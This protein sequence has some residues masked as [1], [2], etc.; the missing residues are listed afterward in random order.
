MKYFV[1]ANTCTGEVNFLSNNLNGI[2]KIYLIQSEFAF[3]V[4]T[5]IMRL[6]AYVQSQGS[7]IELIYNPLVVNTLDGFIMR[8][9][10]I[11]VLNSELMTVNNKSILVDIDSCIKK[12][13]YSYDVEL[14]NQYQT[15]TNQKKQC[16]YSVYEG[17]KKI[18]DEWEQLYIDNM[19]FEM[20]NSFCD[21]IINGF[22]IVSK[23]FNGSRCDRFFGAAYHNTNVNYID[24]ITSEIQT[25]YFI[26][27]RPGTGK[28]T[29]LKK[30]ANHFET[31]GYS[32]EVYHCG[33]DSNSLDMVVCRELSVCVFDSTS[34]HEKFPQK[35]SD[36][37]LDFYLN[38]G[39]GGVDEKLEPK[40]NDVKLR[41]GKM[42][43]LSKIYMEEIQQAYKNFESKIIPDTD[44][45]LLNNIVYEILYEII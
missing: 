30:L 35:V 33:F 45:Q 10:K 41:Y 1:R 28:S 15:E 11:A 37:I 8:N 26:K 22:N 40:L 14:A 32:T 7:D 42:I 4:S 43:S 6:C 23:S 9:K 31:N 13:R 3:I 24:D 21:N 38:S 12:K 29:F 5:F 17:A 20:L 16:I 34:P 27:G 44:Y 36:K 19:D 18:H 25:R 39:L 2:E